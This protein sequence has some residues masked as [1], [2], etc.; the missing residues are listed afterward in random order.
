M[1][2]TVSRSRIAP[3]A[4]ELEATYGTDPTIDGAQ[5]GF[6]TTNSDITFN[7][8]IQVT[9]FRNHGTS[10][11]RPKDVIGQRVAT[12]NFTTMLQ[13]SGT[14]GTAV[15]GVNDLLACSG[16]TETIVAVTSTTYR[17]STVALLKSATIQTEHNGLTHKGNGCYANMML[18][19][20]AGE[21]TLA[22]FAAQGIYTAP[23]IG[24]IASWGVGATGV[25]RARP[26]L[27]ITGSINN[28]TDN[29]V[30]P[31]I[32][33]YDLDAGNDIRR[34]PDALAATGLKA[35]LFADRNPKMTVS[36]ALDTDVAGVII[37]ANEFYADI[38]A[39]VTHAITI[40]LGA[41]AGNINTLSVPTGQPTNVQQGT[42]DGF[43]TLDVTYKVQ[44]ATAETE[45]S[46]AQT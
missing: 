19:A 3:C 14:A 24:S 16:L 36:M 18:K 29:W 23:A 12:F 46:L 26:N 4:A 28:G 30:A 35:L 31:T 8:D 9:E 44:H 39:S 41:T 40:V 22:T 33:G 1:A 13:G 17:P 2:F 45:W 32:L 25:D 20:K 43:R 10:F 34:I 6:N 21:P 5:D 11:T 42:G 38:I 37:Q 7:S 27:G 15:Q